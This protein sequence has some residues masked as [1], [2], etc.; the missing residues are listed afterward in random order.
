MHAYI[1]E[2]TYF[3]FKVR[4][5]SENVYFLDQLSHDSF[6]SCIKFAVGDKAEKSTEG[7]EIF[8]ID[9]QNIIDFCNDYILFFLIFFCLISHR[10]NER[11]FNRVFG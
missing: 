3:E 6:E 9:L 11:V 1:C 5:S 7:I 4:G 10:D 2:R 8:F